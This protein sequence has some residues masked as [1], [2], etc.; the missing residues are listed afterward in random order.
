M[1]CHQS[2]QFLVDFAFVLIVVTF[3]DHQARPTEPAVAS[4]EVTSDKWI[5]QIVFTSNEQVLLAPED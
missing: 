2:I 4:W 1:F 5:F 3:R